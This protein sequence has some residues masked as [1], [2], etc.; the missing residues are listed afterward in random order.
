MACGKGQLVDWTRRKASSLT[1]GPGL[2]LTGELKDADGD[3]DQ[4]RTYHNI[5]PLDSAFVTACN[6][7]AGES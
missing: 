4:S 7:I 6:L 2:C 1:T 3:Q 5:D